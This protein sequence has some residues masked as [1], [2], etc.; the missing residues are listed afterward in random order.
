MVKTFYAFV[1][2][3]NGIPPEDK[4]KKHKKIRER[5]IKIAEKKEKK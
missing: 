2:D 1:L 3:N 4:E 5:P